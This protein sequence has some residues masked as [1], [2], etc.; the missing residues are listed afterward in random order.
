V[1]EFLHNYGYLAVFIGTFLEGEVIL[2]LAGLA[3]HQGLMSFPVVVAVAV[4]GGFAGDQFLFFLGRHYG[5]NVVARFPKLAAKVPRVKALL[6]RWDAPLVI[7]IR[8]MY[9]VRIA[10]P[11]VIGAAGIAPWRLAVFNFIGALIWAPLVATVG[12]GAGHAFEP[13]MEDLRR[14]EI[15]GLVVVACIF[16]ALLF[17]YKRKR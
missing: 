13:F 6:R 10:G 11:I 2:A 14:V 5:D 1:Q 12:Y 8:F 16:L 9:G 7:T 3:A 17:F 4:V 15:V